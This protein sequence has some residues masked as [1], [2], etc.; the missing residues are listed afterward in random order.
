E[1]ISDKNDYE[2]NKDI[3]LDLTKE[4]GLHISDSKRQTN[5]N[6]L[7]GNEKI[8]YEIFNAVDA[9]WNDNSISTF[10]QFEAK[11]K[12][13]G[14]GVEYKFKRG[15]SEV[16]GLWYTRKGKRFPASKIDRRFSYGNIKALLG[17]NR[18]L[19]P[20]SK[21][22]YADGS[23]V[24]IK[25]YK[26]FQFTQKQINDYV[27]GK[28][29]RVDGCQGNYPTVYIKFD[30]DRMVP[31][32]YSSNPD[33]P[34]RSTSTQSQGAG[35]ALSSASFRS[36]AQDDQGFASG[37]GISDDFKLWLSRHPGLSIDEA[38]RR[39]RDEQKAKQRRSGPKLH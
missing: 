34:Q 22:L 15:T 32:F 25:S 5:V 1:T 21:W 28:I 9:A 8:R 38:L 13:S 10:K 26:G 18:P 33:V 35:I 2:R 23:I 29:I 3:C 17:K 6:R 4:Y 7:R 27:A 31:G 19:H 12:A 11:L 39:Y 24:P 16:Q 36:G 30:S 37:D 20:L 14:V